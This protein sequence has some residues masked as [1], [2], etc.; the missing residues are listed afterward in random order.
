MTYTKEYD[1][2]LSRLNAPE[3]S[4][5]PYAPIPYGP[6]PNKCNYAN[7]NRIMAETRQG[8]LPKYSILQ[9]IDLGN[10]N[11]LVHPSDNVEY[12]YT[13]DPSFTFATGARKSIAVRKVDIYN[14]IPHGQ[15][16]QA[17]E[18]FF[19][20]FTITVQKKDDDGTLQPQFS[21]D[22]NLERTVT[23][24]CSN[25]KL[26]SLNNF[27]LEFG[28]MVYRRIC[29]KESLVGWFSS[30]FYAGYDEKNNRIRISVFPNDENIHF[31]RIACNPAPFWI[32][33]QS[34]VFNY[35][36]TTDSSNRLLFVSKEGNQ[37][38]FNIYIPIPDT[39]LDIRRTSIS[40]T[41]N[42]WTKNNLIAPLQYDSDHL[43][44][45]FPYN[46]NPEI[47]FWFVDEEGNKIRWKWVRG[48]IDLE[49]IIDNTDTYAMDT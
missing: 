32:I 45:V 1:E 26:V 25:D 43:S 48:Y 6:V 28:K 13:L 22:I 35:Y 42:P 10:Q 37:N 8:T 27:A 30:Q 31:V 2:A 9:R 38:V 4:P 14:V 44:K 34:N 19:G 21:E 36:N 7:W 23:Y 11:D 12:V 41:I 20:K 17:I 15:T 16:V 39:I 33:Q 24:N 40:G 49:L 47:R 3:R 29:E 5:L 46:G 18:N